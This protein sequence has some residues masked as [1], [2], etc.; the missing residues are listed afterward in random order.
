MYLVAEGYVTRTRVG[1]RN[2]GRATQPSDCGTLH[3]VRHDLDAG[4]LLR[5]N[6]AR[7]RKS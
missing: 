6:G 1:R 2:R 7:S 4:A 5:L 3:P